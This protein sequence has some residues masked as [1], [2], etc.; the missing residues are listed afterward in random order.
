MYMYT[1]YK[2]EEDIIITAGVWETVVKDIH[3]Y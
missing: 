1:Y 3:M 2:I